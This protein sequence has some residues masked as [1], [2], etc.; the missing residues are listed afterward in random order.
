M[1]RKKESGDRTEFFIAVLAL[2]MVREIAGL[3]CQNP[4]NSG[5]FPVQCGTPQRLGVMA[6]KFGVG[7]V[8]C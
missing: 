2:H 3:V 6:L 1:E 8:F 5:G 7:L 4:G